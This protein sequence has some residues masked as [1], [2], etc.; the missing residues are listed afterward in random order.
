MKQ[1]LRALALTLTLFVA[2]PAPVVAAAGAPRNNNNEA[3]IF[4]YAL[5]AALGIGV[6]WWSFF[7]GKKA[8]KDSIQPTICA[9]CTHTYDPEDLITL[10]PHTKEYATYASPVTN[11]SQAQ[12]KKVQKARLAKI[13]KQKHKVCPTCAID[14]FK[15]ALRYT[16]ANEAGTCLYHMNASNAQ[17][18]CQRCDGHGACLYCPIAF[19]DAGQHKCKLLLDINWVDRN[20][21]QIAKTINKLCNNG[22]YDDNTEHLL[23]LWNTMCVDYPR[24]IREL[25]AI[26]RGERDRRATIGN[27]WLTKWNRI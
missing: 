6:A 16:N 26:K 27:R 20:N 13:P 22:T 24:A 4:G 15:D 2:A 8:V 14:I 3:R 25:K 10:H 17:G 18:I 7:G 9:R 12:D 5:M 11:K 23:T 21:P 19:D 1:L